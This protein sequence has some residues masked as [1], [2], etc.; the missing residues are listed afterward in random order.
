MTLIAQGCFP[1]LNS[2]AQPVSVSNNLNAFIKLVYLALK[3]TKTINLS[4]K[5]KYFNRELKQRFFSV[6]TV[7]FKPSNAVDVKAYCKM[8]WAV[9]FSI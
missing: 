1:I 9:I 3:P 2:F 8:I 5:L 7:A 6:P 4:S